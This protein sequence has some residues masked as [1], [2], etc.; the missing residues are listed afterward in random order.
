MQQS[1]VIF[2]LCLKNTRARKSHD[3]RVVIVYRKLLFQNVF[4]FHENEKPAF[5]NSSGVKSVFAKLC[6]RDGLVGVSS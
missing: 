6:F 2:Y 3:Y 1:P 5:P 4:L